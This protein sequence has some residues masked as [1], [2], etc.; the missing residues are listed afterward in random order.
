MTATFIAIASAAVAV[1][2]F[3]GYPVRIS[4]LCAASAVVL[5]AVIL[6]KSRHPLNIP[7]LLGDA[8]Y[9]IYLWH[10]F[11]I[12]KVAPYVHA[13]SSKS[14]L[15]VAYILAGVT[16]GVAAHLLI[17]RPLLR[18]LRSRV[19]MRNVPNPGGM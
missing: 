8:S 7:L 9:S 19:W 13:I 5:A 3:T 4:A 1:R 2:Q 16:F 17:E 11:V 14:V 6:E 12:W 10:Y 18:A 15:F